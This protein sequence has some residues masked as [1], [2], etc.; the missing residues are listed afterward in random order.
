MQRERIDT[1]SEG[2]RRHH[3]AQAVE[4]MREN[5]GR[6]RRDARGFWS[7]PDCPTEVIFGAVVPIWN[8]GDKVIR[9]LIDDGLAAVTGRHGQEPVE[10]ALPELS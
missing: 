5:G 7:W 1:S 9:D 6:L 8:V 2:R 3:M 4:A 10:I